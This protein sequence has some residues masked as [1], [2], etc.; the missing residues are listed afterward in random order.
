M[1]RYRKTLMLQE[2][3]LPMRAN[4]REREP[5]ILKR[6]SELKLYHRIL[7]RRREAPLFL[8]HDGPPYAN[9]RLHM[10]HALNKSLK[11]FVVRYKAMAGFRT[12][13]VPGWD[14]H[15]LPIELNVLKELGSDADRLDQRAIRTR[16]RA[17]ARKYIEIQKEGFRRLGCIGLWENPYLTLDEGF[18]ARILEAFAELSRKK[19]IY[20]GK[21]PI[22]WCPECRTALAAST[23]EAEYADHTSP[24]ITV[25]FP[26]VEESAP[27]IVIWTT[28]PWTLPANVAVAVRADLE[29]VVLRVGERR[30]ILAEPLLLPT[31]AECG[32]TDYSIEEHRSGESL[33]GQTFRHPFLDRTV[34]VILGDFVTT[35]QGTGVVHIAPGHG[36]EDYEVGLK[37]DL[38]ILSPV[39]EKGCFTREAGVFPGTNVFEANEMVIE[40]LREKGALLAVNEIQ[41]QYPHCWRC[42]GPIIFRATA[43]WFLSVDRAL[44][45]GR[46]LRAL[47]LQ[48]APAVRWIPDWGRDRFLGT[49]RD[50]PDWC[51]SRQRAWGVPIPAV[52]CPSCGYGAV[53][54]EVLRSALNSAREG[55][56]DDWFEQDLS[57]DNCPQCGEP[58]HYEKDILDVW[59]DS[60]VSW[61]ATDMIGGGT[62]KEKMPQRADLYLEGS[63]QHR[64]WFQSSLWPALALTGEPPYRAV[65]THG[66]MLDGEGR[67]MHKS[68]GNVISPDEILEKYGA[69]IIRLW[70]ASE[71]FRE[72]VR[73]SYSILDQVADT[74]RKIRNTYRFLAGNILDLDPAYDPDPETLEPLDLWT[75]ARLEQYRER[76]T[77]AFD[78][79]EF[80]NVYRATLELCTN[81]LSSFYLDIVKDRLYCEPAD[82]PSRRAAQSVCRTALSITLRCMAPILCYTT[83]EV[84]ALSNLLPDPQSV[85]SVHLADWPE[86]LPIDRGILEEMEPYLAARRAILKEIEEARSKGTIRSSQMA[87]VTARVEALAE[88]RTPLDLA[89][90][91]DICQVAEI[92]PGDS[93]TVEPTPLPKCPRCWRHREPASSGLCPRCETVVR[94]VAP[95]LLSS[96]A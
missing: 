39:D 51:L 88:C 43:Q 57:G 81:D 45:D 71:N 95:E 13:F 16:C 29:Y 34:P 82:S 1:K 41:H 35:D 60:G 58:L 24:S 27:A 78:A 15:G 46:S 18:E 11:D 17:F 83:D 28:T 50:R 30:Y 85:P 59:F 80:H 33:E 14:C 63:D 76:V 91:R 21:K 84:W 47:A 44:E 77:K 36:Q 9:G 92:V 40:L 69:D 66:F 86:P 8:L 87:R 61:Y 6:W 89:L 7:E 74:Y 55:R 64:G 70:V 75:L 2:S 79:Y 10:G 37:Y 4:L 19:I 62:R 3:P 65:L 96:D 67:A 54:E 56:L 93:L 22:H 68:A 12:P 31:V 32:W 90:L 94:E 5:E 72:D 42:K 73:L 20:R 23:A 49:V 26:P 48:K 53:T 38:P 52:V 25:A